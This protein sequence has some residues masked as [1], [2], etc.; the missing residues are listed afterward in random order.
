MMNSNHRS[1]NDAAATTATAAGGNNDN[2]GTVTT[3]GTTALNNRSSSQSKKKKLTQYYQSSPIP[4]LFDGD[5]NVFNNTSITASSSSSSVVVVAAAA[6][7]FFS[8]SDKTIESKN[9]HTHTHTHSNNAIADGTT[10]ATPAAAISFQKGDNQ[11]A[12]NN[13]NNNIL[14]QVPKCSNNNKY[15]S[16]PIPMS[17]EEEEDVRNSIR[18]HLASKRSSLTIHEFEFVQEMIG[19]TSILLQV[20]ELENM[21]RILHDDQIFFTT[22]TPTKTTKNT[23]TNPKNNLSTPSVPKQASKNSSTINTNRVPKKSNDDDNDNDNDDDEAMAV[24]VGSKQRQVCL[25]AKKKHAAELVKKRVK[26]LWNKARIVSL[27][28]GR[29]P[30]STS[31]SSMIQNDDDGKAQSHSTAIERKIRHKENENNEEKDCEKEREI[32]VASTNTSTPVYF[33]RASTN[34]YQGEGIEIGTVELG[35]DT[36]GAVGD[37]SDD[38]TIPETKDDM[39]LPLRSGDGENNEDDNNSNDEKLDEDHNI[40]SSLSNLSTYDATSSQN[41][42]REKFRRASANVDNGKGF[43]VANED[44]F[45]SVY[46]DINNDDDNDRN[47]GDG[48]KLV[49]ED[50]DPWLFQEFDT[51]GKRRNFMILGTSHNDYD[52][53]PHVLSPI[54]MDRFQA[55]LPDN[56]KCESFWLKYSLVRD[57]ASMITFLKQV[58][59]SPCTLLA[60][61]TVEGDVFGAFVT[62]AWTCQPAY[63]G[64]RATFLWRMKHQR[65]DGNNNTN[66]DDRG[67]G[68][69]ES[70]VDQIQKESNLEIFPSEVYYANN[71][72][73][74]CQQDHIAV[75]GGAPTSTPV[76]FGPDRGGM[77]ASHEVGFGLHLGVDG[78]ILEGTSSPSLTFRNPPL[79]QAHTDGSKFEILNLEV[80]GF[81]PCQTEKEARILEYK[82]MFFRNHSHSIQSV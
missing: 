7:S 71:Y 6:A 22:T 81:S 25:E 77:Y 72:Y 45:K 21:N 14:R 20:D 3:A 35:C 65:S 38:I 55:F 12:N 51:T 46:D 60:I 19:D 66:N 36:V 42:R 28:V 29:L 69:G 23:N 8:L 1:S 70:L 73:Q 47:E 50:Y 53:H 59:A 16:G 80:W 30:S 33:R 39:C 41:A 5:P 62:S 54:Q 11:R 68:G 52:C 64:S 61:E 18:G 57:G 37:Q 82:N 27:L 4:V 78:S 9:N 32:A 10:V 67:G 26:K 79:A 43:E 15:K 13:H 44:L 34:A 40:V 63:F 74:I 2:D 76:D 31:S 56:K 49:Y 17:H 24:V 58:R 48:K 75:G